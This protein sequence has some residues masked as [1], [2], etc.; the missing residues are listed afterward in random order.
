[1]V[2]DM[3]K[4]TDSVDIVPIGPCRLQ[5]TV[6]QA[7]SGF[8]QSTK[9]F[10]SVDCD[11]SV[12]GKSVALFMDLDLNSLYGPSEFDALLP[13]VVS[14]NIDVLPLSVVSS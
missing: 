11:G 7:V 1:M 12:S 9:T 3:L 4:E 2:A 14:A 13:S 8:L 6:M 10:P 5:L